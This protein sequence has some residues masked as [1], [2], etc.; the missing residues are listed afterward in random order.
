MKYERVQGFLQQLKRPH[1]RRKAEI[2]P[3]EMLMDMSECVE[4]LDSALRRFA[5]EPQNGKRLDGISPAEAWQQCSGEK[6]HVLLPDSLRYLLGTAES[7]ATVRSEGIVLRIGRVEKQ[8]CGSDKLG[9]L[10]GEKVRVRYNEELPDMIAV[11][12]IAADP[13]GLHPFSVPLFQELPAHGASAEQ[14]A[15]AREHQNRF[16][17]Y[18][19]ALYRELA[20]RTNKTWSSSQ[21]GSPEMRAAG[22]AH[23]R[24]EREHIELTTRRARERGAIR[25]LAAQQNLAIDPNRLKRPERSRERL[26][27]AEEKRRQILAL[28]QEENA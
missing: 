26:V 10:I 22:E 18:G 20:P 8:Y 16:A 23:N 25:Q 14:F 28:E 2:D 17:S 4:I 19:R 27:S 24:V 12:H 15:E 21:L 1:Q 9:A 6:A 11:T 5:N 3:R 7:E 13:R